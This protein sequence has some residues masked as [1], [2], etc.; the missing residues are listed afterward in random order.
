MRTLTSPL[1]L[2]IGAQTG[3]PYRNTRVQQTITFVAHRF[4]HDTFVQQIS[5]FNEHLKGPRVDTTLVNKVA[6][7]DD[8]K[9]RAAL[10]AIRYILNYFEF[11]SVG[12]LS[13]NFD[14]EIIRKTMRGN[15]TF[16]YDRC[17]RY[18]SECQDINPKALEHFTKM[19][20]HFKDLHT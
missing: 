12:I 13:G 15:F 9:D 18:I 5:I 10:Q 2:P 14:E 4:T 6:V 8:P 3:P 7:S 16:Y 20:A 11:L 1:G 19:R 17:M